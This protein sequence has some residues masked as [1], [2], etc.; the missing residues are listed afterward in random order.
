[1]GDWT[2]VTLHNDRIYTHQLMRISY[3]TYDIRRED[4]VV[5]IKADPNVMVLKDTLAWSSDTENASNAPPYRYARVLGIFHADVRFLGVLS[6]GSRDYTPHRLDFLWVRW[7]ISLGYPGL[8]SLELER[9]QFSPLESPDAF[10]FISPREVVRG[11]HLIPDFNG[12]RLEEKDLHQAASP[13]L[14]RSTPW[15]SYY[16]NRFVAST[17]CEP[18]LPLSFRCVDLSTEICS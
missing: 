1:M 13:W 9:L 5:R 11:V 14:G 7:Y 6:D 8:E 15:S 17:L 3:T 16:L 18:Y 4:D 2:N 12:G 10:G